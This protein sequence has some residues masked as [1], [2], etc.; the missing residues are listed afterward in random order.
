MARSTRNDTAFEL[1]NE[2]AIREARE[3]DRIEPRASTV[4]YD[5]RKGLIIVE[6]RSGYAFGFPPERVAGLERID[7]EQLRA[8]RI[9]PSGDGLHW[10]DL[11]VDISVT[12][13]I[14]D[15]LNLGEW[16]PRIMGQLRSKAKARAARL[17]GLKGGRPRSTK[18]ARNK[19]N[20]TRT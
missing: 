6:L 2:T 16:A 4:T 8:V 7:A 5:A 14:A 13:L 10:D 9:S 12:G 1:Q 3:A 20:R 15:A 18:S 11:N 17:N 19:K